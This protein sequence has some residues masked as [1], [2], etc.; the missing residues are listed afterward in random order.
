MTP[1]G[2]QVSFRVND[3]QGGAEEA[4]ASSPACGGTR[5]SWTPAPRWPRSRPG[6]SPS[7]TRVDLP[8]R[9]ERAEH[10]RGDR[11]RSWPSWALVGVVAETLTRGEFNV[12]I[13]RVGRPEV[14]NMMLAPKD[15]DQVNRDLEIRDLY[16]MDDAFH[17]G[18]SYAGAFRARLDANLAFWDGLDGKQDW[19]TARTAAPAHRARARRLPGRRRHQALRRAGVVPR[20]RAGRPARGAAPDVRGP[21]V[22]RRRDGHDLHPARQRRPRAHDPRRG[23]RRHPAG[24][25]HASPTWRRPTRTRPKPP[26]HH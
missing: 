13:E 1:S 9:Q 3:E 14:K 11:H 4:S 20:D 22:E 25:G 12:R 19:P 7:P 10:R 18:E 26:E 2:E 16:N 23:R 6:S 24:H 17:L 5:S 21:H 15:F 8:G